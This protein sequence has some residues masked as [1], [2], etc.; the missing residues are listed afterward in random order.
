MISLIHPTRGRPSMCL[1]TVLKWVGLADNPVD[2]LLAIDAADW[3][4]YLPTATEVE[5]LGGRVA[6]VSGPRLE[7]PLPDPLPENASRWSTAVTKVNFLCASA[8][9]QWLF[10]I[11]DDFFPVAEGWD[12]ELL[13]ILAD[14]PSKW[15]YDTDGRFCHPVMSR[16]YY[17]SR[18]F[19]FFP[20]FIHVC[21]DTDLCWTARALGSFGACENRGLFQH[22]HPLLDL[23][24]TG[25]VI[26][27]IGNRDVIFDQGNELLKQR[28]STI[29]EAT[30]RP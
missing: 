5:G 17:E 15:V 11:A 13:S 6:K 2:Y 28:H 25:D 4:S 10:Y 26:H 18:G 1:E 16:G 8:T 20:G 9:G 7:W 23:S 27:Q 12:T 14:A 3:E 19:F 24:V 29:Y 30:R 22:A 21:S